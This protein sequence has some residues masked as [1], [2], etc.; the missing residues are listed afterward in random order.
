MEGA[1]FSA[2]H[3][4]LN[5]TYRHAGD[6]LRVEVSKPFTKSLWA[7]PRSVGEHTLIHQ[8]CEEEIDP[9]GA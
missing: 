6:P 3:G 1:A 9:L 8:T 5:A 4:P 2:P 7:C